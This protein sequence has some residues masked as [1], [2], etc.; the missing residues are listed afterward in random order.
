MTQNLENDKLE[1]D[2]M[3][4]TFDGKNNKRVV[5]LV[6][7]MVAILIISIISYIQYSRSATEDAAHNVSLFYLEELDSNVTQ[8]FQSHFDGYF[9]EL[10]L[11]LF[12]TRAAETDSKRELEYHMDNMADRGQFAY[13]AL[14]DE[15][16]N[17]YINDPDYESQYL[18]DFLRGCDTARGNI[19]IEKCE[20]PDGTSSDVFII[21]QAALAGTTVMDGKKIVLG[22]KGIPAEKV[23]KEILLRGEDNDAFV[24]MIMPDGTYLIAGDNEKLVKSDNYFSD[25]GATA[26][27]EDGYSLEKMQDD[28][29]NQ[30]DN[31]TA[32]YIGDELYY[33]YYSFL[34]RSGWSLVV[35]V[36]FDTIMG[37][38]E[39]TANR[40]TFGGI[41]VMMLMVIVLAVIFVIFIR[42][43]NTSLKLN[44]QRIEAEERNLAKS[45]FLSSMSHDIRTPMNAIIGFTNLALRQ[46][47]S[48]R[49]QE[50]LSKISTSSNHLLSLINDVLDMSRIESGKM[51]IEWT[52]CNLSEILH[53]LQT[54]M[55]GQVTAKQQHL[56]MDVLDVVNEN[57]WCDKMRMNQVLLNFLSNAVKF[58][59]AGGSITVSLAQKKC[60]REGYGMYE[61]RVKDTG[62]GMTEEFAKKVFEPFER[63]KSETV[64]KIQGTGLGMS[65]AKNIIDMMG[66]TVRVETALHKGTEF[67]V[68][69]ELKIQE[70]MDEVDSS[71]LEKLS[72]LK[73]MVVDDDFAACDG[74]IKS[75][76]RFGMDAEWS[77]SGREALL[78]IKQSQELDKSY[79]VFIIDWQLPD[80]NGLEVIRQIRRISDEDI[81]VILMSSYSWSD[82]ENEAEEVGV[83]AFCSKPIFMS[84][85]QRTLVDVLSREAEEDKGDPLERFKGSR[86]LLVEDNE[87]NREIA[88]EILQEY[89][90][91]VENAEN[92]QVAVDK[93]AAAAAGYYDV[94]LMDIQMPVMDGYEATKEIRSLPDAQVAAVPIMAMTANAFEEDKRNALEAGMNGHIAKPID[95]N[96]LLEVLNE[97][98]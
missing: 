88:T 46:E 17:V 54:I 16:G 70:E 28:I 6:V 44:M 29:K 78:R 72:G 61:F 71:E 36:P 96:V 75:L 79:N 48:P 43:R 39:K 30:H 67:I 38:M 63:E 68:N 11:A 52:K 24:H 25:L 9:K 60:D 84:D 87:L 83:S 40:V 80:L 91:I 77:M 4:E 57:V 62:I 15:D 34:P 86:L 85:L 98:L 21:A 13:Y 76:H 50:Y 82:I 56:H 51:N 23:R 94:V 59:P 35:T 92:G 20:M 32:Y 95:V 27:F 10:N 65:I 97:T 47:N 37:T 66:G 3:E 26:V 42:Q 14:L 41:F 7:G 49:V 2:K 69:V 22:A 74:I 58:T 73:A 5:W 81:P 55:Q 89:D 53:G 18:A 90:F 93:V 31:S 33:G 64:N 1:H 8:V 45:T 19:T 12:A